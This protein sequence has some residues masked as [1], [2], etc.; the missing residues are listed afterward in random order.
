MKNTISKSLNTAYWYFV[1]LCIV[2]R[3][4]QQCRGPSLE[5]RE[6]DIH[7][8]NQNLKSNKVW[9]NVLREE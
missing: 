6:Q 3:D 4:E 9:R 1:F 8:G 2:F 5:T 7:Y